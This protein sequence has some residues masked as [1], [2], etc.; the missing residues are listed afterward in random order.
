[1]FT[2]TVNINSKG[3]SLLANGK[4]TANISFCATEKREGGFQ[5]YTSGVVALQGDV[6]TVDAMLAAFTAG[7]KIKITLSVEE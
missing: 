3:E 5:A 4:K 6:A 2:T 1:M 7:K